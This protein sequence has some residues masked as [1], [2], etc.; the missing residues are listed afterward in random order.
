M[1]A[2]VTLVGQPQG[3]RIEDGIVTFKL[4]TGPASNTAPTPSGPPTLQ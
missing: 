3:L 2:K 1:S 4:I